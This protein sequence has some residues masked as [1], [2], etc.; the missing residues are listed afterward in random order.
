MPET[1]RP[2]VYRIPLRDG[3]CR[4]ARALL[5]LHVAALEG[6]RAATITGDDTLVVVAEVDADL[7][8]KLV[9]A[10]VRAGLD[11]LLVSVIPLDHLVD[12]ACLPAYP[13]PAAG[14]V[15]PTREARRA[16]P[17]PITAE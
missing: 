7:S 11:P 6:V 1:T 13:S 16:A 2:P 5:Q 15:E 17:A 9:A 3:G 8:D 10:V 14:F 12:P 4:S